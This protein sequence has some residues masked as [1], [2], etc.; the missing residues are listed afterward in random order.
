MYGV[1]FWI[2]SGWRK[3]SKGNT[4]TYGIKK[5]RRAIDWVIETKINY[6]WE[7]YKCCFKQ[8]GWISIKLLT[9]GANQERIWKI[10]E[11]SW[12]GRWSLEKEELIN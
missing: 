10:L 5:V 7:K 6:P 8:K 2:R 4:G 11:M 1:V 3:K 12:T 9:D